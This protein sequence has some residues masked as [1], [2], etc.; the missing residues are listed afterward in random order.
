MAKLF[1]HLVF[2]NFLKDKVLNSL[3][4]LGLALGLTASLIIL[5]YADHELSYDEFHPNFENTYRLEGI[6][7]GDTWFSNLGAEHS[8]ELV[9]GK[10]PEV[11]FIVELSSSNRTFVT[12]EQSSFVEEHA[13]QV[14]PG[15]QFLD[16]FGFELLQGNRQRA[17]EAP[18][19]VIMTASTAERYFGESSALDKVIYYDSIPLKVSGVIADIPSNAHLQ[20]DMLRTNPNSFGDNHYHSHSYVKLVAGAD[21]E[22][23]AEKVLGMEGI[24]YNE[25]HELSQARLIR[26]DDIYFNSQSSFGSGGTGDK[27][28]L[29][30]FLVIGGLILLISVANY[31]N[32]SL[33]I[34]SSKGLEIGMRK[35][36]G[37]SRFQVLRAFFYESFTVTLLTVPLV[38][39][40]LQLTIP[41]FNDFQEITLTNKLLESP[42]YIIGFLSFLI[43]LSVVTVIYPATVLNN[44]QINTLIKSKSAIHNS[45]GIRL[46]NT[47]IFVQFLL[48][49]TLGISAWFMNRQ[50]SYLDGK[51]MGF[52]ATGVIKVTNPWLLG[53]IGAYHV[54]KA[55]LLK[56]P[57]IKAVSFGP[58][59]G[60][61]NQALAYQPEGSDETFEN[62]LSYGVDIDY[63]DVMGMS[64]TDGDFKKVLQSAE[65]G[66]VVSL[67]NQTFLH[68]YGWEQDPIGKKLKLRPGTENEL[69][70]QVSAVFK[71][72]HYF[73]LKEKVSP[74]IISLK[75]DPDFVNTNILIKAAVPDMNAVAKIIEEE[76][77]K[78]S[79]N[80]PIRH[81]NMEEAV[82]RMYAKE[83]Q[84]G[85][86]TL[87][88]SVLAVGLSILGLVGFM[89]Y[90]IGL[91]SKE[92]AVRKVLG[93]SVVQIIGMLNRQLFWAIL[94]SATL[95]SAISYW[96]VGEWLSD[97]AYKITL[98]PVAFVLAG[99]IVYFIVFVIT[100]LQSVKSAVVNPVTA[101]KYE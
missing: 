80:S 34:Y 39:L 50:V 66:Q 15:S 92:I 91:K 9:S 24:A 49:F 98:N 28:Q 71:D 94:V 8:K 85:Q 54:F 76:W 31:I 84:T 75:N 7:N 64:I 3:N 101:L 88:F 13:M 32:L 19:Q 52:D 5:M 86:I 14:K 4:V 89:I 29:T 93:A 35:V 18:N 6:T 44:T 26:V 58:M 46:R 60:D 68:M 43:I 99:C 41:L 56:H 77:Y 62:L 59:M 17:L 45:T 16:L 27:L 79:P 25:F 69:N 1:L 42:P 40:G 37:E 67:V 55:E 82:K 100:G 21:P 47:L 51:D 96:L 36:L 61:G 90:M 83:K 95:G 12:Y 87:T 33:A 30:V 48:L 38:L 73:N 65:D 78:I 57:Q 72:F 2:R 63:F 11:E 70:R 20:F 97:Y 74:Q 81:D 23:L 10:Y 22:L 53:D